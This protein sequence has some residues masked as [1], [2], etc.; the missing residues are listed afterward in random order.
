MCTYI[1]I[2]IDPPTHLYTLQTVQE[3]R[4]VQV[5]ELGL[6]NP[7]FGQTPIMVDLNGDGKPDLLWVNMDGPTRAFLN[8]SRNNSFVVKV[9]ETAALLGTRVRIESS[10]GE[11]YTREVVTG[12]G[13]MSDQS[14][15]LVFGLGEAERVLRVVISHVDGSTQTIEA[16]GAGIRLSPV[17]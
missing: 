2:H 11:S 1:Y 16:P 3:D 9:P 4:F 10:L 15:D 12:V 13:L 14:P 5:D 6:E 17:Y 7:Y 8:T